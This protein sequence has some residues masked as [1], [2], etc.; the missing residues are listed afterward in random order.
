MP[1]IFFWHGMAG[2]FLAWHLM[3]IVGI[4][5]HGFSLA[6]HGFFFVQ[7]GMAYFFSCLAGYGYFFD[8]A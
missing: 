5:W 1:W 3:A 4:A 7:H 8:M 2:I 6:W